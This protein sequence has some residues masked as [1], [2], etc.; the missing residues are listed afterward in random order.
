M[1]TVASHLNQPSDAT[2]QPARMRRLRRGGAACLVLATMGASLG[3]LSF[4]PRAPSLVW[5][6]TE[7]V[8]TG[9]YWISDA[10]PAR[11]DIVA[12]VPTGAT[13]D[14]L[15]ALGVLPAGKVLLKRLSAVQDDVVCRSGASITINGAE[16]ARARLTTGDGHPLPAWSGCHVLGADEILVLA[17]HPLSFDGRYLGPIEARQIIGVATPLITFPLAGVS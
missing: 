1:G 4:L 12:L 5:N 3:L 14:M 13:R 15:A 10:K 6:F 16:A 11:D 8:P 2:R 9:L 17:P 7:S